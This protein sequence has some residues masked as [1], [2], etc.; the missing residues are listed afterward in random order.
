MRAPGAR[1]WVIMVVVA[2]AGI[3]SAAV[4]MRRRSL[5]HRQRASFYAGQ[6]R[7]AVRR[8]GLEAEGIA[9][10]REGLSRVKRNGGNGEALKGWADQL[11]WWESQ[12]ANDR[13]R[14]ATWARLKRKYERAASRPW[15][16]LTP[17]PAEPPSVPLLPPPDLPALPPP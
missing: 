17:G 1:L 6:E 4:V 14:A 7:E 11:S 15:E 16:P 12:A 3:A 8:I 2:V 5:D 10:C 9:H 13:N